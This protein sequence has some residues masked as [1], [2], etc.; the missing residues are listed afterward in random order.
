M[1]D[2]TGLWPRRQRELQHS[3]ACEQFHAEEPDFSVN[4]SPLSPFGLFELGLSFVGKIQCWETKLC[5][6]NREM[7][8]P[9]GS[10]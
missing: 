4:F 1:D 10:D 8:S 3:M 2:A 9:W 5:F 6:T 7:L